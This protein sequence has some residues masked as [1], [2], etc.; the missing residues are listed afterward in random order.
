MCCT[1]NLYTNCIVFMFKSCISPPRPCLVTLSQ[2]CHYSS[3]AEQETL[4][5]LD[6]ALAVMKRAK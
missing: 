6:Y 3:D 2:I 1:C 4:F 5:C